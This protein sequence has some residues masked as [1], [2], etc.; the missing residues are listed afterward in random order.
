M[1]SDVSRTPRPILGTQLR[2]SYSAAEL[3]TPSGEV[4]FNFGRQDHGRVKED[5]VD[6]LLGRNSPKLPF[7]GDHSEPKKT[8]YSDRM[9]MSKGMLA[10]VGN[11]RGDTEKEMATLTRG[12]CRETTRSTE[13][14]RLAGPNLGTGELTMGSPGRARVVGHAGS[15]SWDI[16]R[17]A[18]VEDAVPQAEGTEVRTDTSGVSVQSRGNLDSRVH[19]TD[20]RQTCSRIGTGSQQLY[21]G[22]RTAPISD[23]FLPICGS[24]EK[25]AKFDEPISFRYYFVQGFKQMRQGN[26][27]MDLATCICGYL[28][29]ISLLIK[30]NHGST[31]KKSVYGTSL[32]LDVLSMYRLEINF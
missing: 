18:S 8:V 17:M 24:Q 9:G 28:Y 6:L 29:C 20:S 7:T 12:S 3:G 14:Q 27:T 10:S 23:Y 32:P 26:K 21:R 31:L 1:F 30:T 25:P 13:V 4:E 19:E 2:P 11:L 16:N 5:Q 15:G 22:F